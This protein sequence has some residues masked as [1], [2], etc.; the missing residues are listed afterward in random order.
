[1]RRGHGTRQPVIRADN[2]R[3]LE[4]RVLDR[5]SCFRVRTQDHRD[6]PPRVAFLR[7]ELHLVPAGEQ[8]RAALREQPAELPLVHPPHNRT[9][10]RLA[11]MQSARPKLGYQHAKQVVFNAGNIQCK[12]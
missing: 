3:R 12:L 10:P 5:A 2:G 6:T 8:T 11:R 4:R 9:R 1:M 7:L